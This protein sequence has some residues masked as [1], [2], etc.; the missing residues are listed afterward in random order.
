[1]TGPRRSRA[2]QNQA[3]GK[4][5]RGPPPGVHG[6]S[7]P[8]T[9][10]VRGTI[11]PAPASR[12]SFLRPGVAIAAIIVGVVLVGTVGLSVLRGNAGSSSPS[13]S[14]TAPLRTPI[15]NLAPPAATPLASPPA[16]PSGDGTK[17]TISTQLGT[18]V[19]EM[20]N[21]SAPVAAQN[22]VNLA[23]AGFY[24]GTTFHRLV[25]GFVIQGGDPNG[26]GSGGPGYTIPDEP[27]VG[28]YRR[29][30]VAMARTSQPHS[31]GSQFFIVLDD[32]ASQ[33]LDQARTYVIFGNVVQGM[34][35][36]DKIAAMPN[37]GGQE[38][39]A[40]NPVAMNTVTVQGP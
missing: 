18:I 13:P 29:G 36:V 14:A 35:V 19:I 28:A 12:S 25:P 9:R 38:N 26:N 27:V 32:A 33:S 30:I 24:N 39:R 1:V 22:F 8:P 5:R 16:Q 4:K 2:G 6:K 23:K 10:P 20:Y 7:G 11:R 40:I 37:S 15:G 34:D 17:A 21:R 31:Q 3:T